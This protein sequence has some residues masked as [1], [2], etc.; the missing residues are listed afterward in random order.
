MED[1]P[2]SLEE[3]LEGDAEIL[4]A[5]SGGR[6][7]A[8]A[9]GAADGAAIGAR[10][11]LA[12]AARCGASAGAAW[13]ISRV[14]PPSAVPARARVSG[15]AVLAAAVKATLLRAGDEELTPA[16]EALQDR[17]PSGSACQ[18]ASLVGVLPRAP[19]A[20]R[21]AWQATGDAKLLP[22]SSTLA[23]GEAS[24]AS[25]RPFEAEL[26]RKRQPLRGCKASACCVRCC[27]RVRDPSLFWWEK[28][29]TV[30]AFF[31]VLALMWAMSVA[32][33]WPSR[34]QVW[35]SF[36]LVFNA[37]SF[38]LQ[39]LAER[40]AGVGLSV[41][42]AQRYISLWG[43]PTG[44]WAHP[45]AWAALVPALA[46]VVALRRTVAR[47]CCPR[48]V[49]CGRA[50]LLDAGLAASILLSLP[51]QLALLRVYTCES[52]PDFG[53]ALRWGPD[54]SWPCFDAEDLR[55]TL[56]AALCAPALLIALLG[57]T[58]ALAWSARRAVPPLAGS[59]AHERFLRWREAAY[60]HAIGYAWRRDGLWTM[61]SFVGPGGAAGV[62]C[63]DIDGGP[64]AVGRGGGLA[65][66]LTCGGVCCCRVTALSP[67]FMRAQWAA[68]TTLLALVYALARPSPLAQSIVLLVVMLLWAL[69]QSFRPAFRVASSNR[70]W[71][72]ALWG[73]T[74]FAFLSLFRAAGFQAQFTV[75][76]FFALAMAWS[77]CVMAVL[78][79]AVL[80]HAAVA[81]CRRGQGLVAACCRRRE[82]PEP[83][84]RWALA[85]VPIGSAEAWP[86]GTVAPPDAAAADEEDDEAAAAIGTTHLLPD[87]TEGLAMV[88]AAQSAGLW[89]ASGPSRSADLQAH[90]SAGEHGAA[91]AAMAGAQ[92]PAGD[93][94]AMMGGRLAG[95]SA[96]MFGGS[97]VLGTDSSA[98][99]TRHRK[100]NRRGRSAIAGSSRPSGVGADSKMSVAPRAAGGAG[101]AGRGPTASSGAGGELGAESDDEDFE[102]GLEQVEDD[103]SD[104]EDAESDSDDA[105]S[106]TFPDAAHQ[107]LAVASSARHVLALS[108][109]EAVEECA[110]L[111]EAA[112]AGSMIPWPQGERD[113]EAARGRIVGRPLDLSLA[114]RRTRV[115]LLKLLAFS[116]FVGRRRLKR[117]KH[118]PAPADDA[119][120]FRLPLAAAAALLQGAGEAP[121]TG[122]V[123]GGR[124]RPFAAFASDPEVRAIVPA[125]LHPDDVRAMDPSRLLHVTA[126]AVGQWA[127]GVA[128][129][130]VLALHAVIAACRERWAQHID[131]AEAR[132]PAAKEAAATRRRGRVAWYEAWERCGRTLQLRH[133]DL[134]EPA[135]RG[136]R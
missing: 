74:W 72:L 32:W 48:D 11:G 71:L 130:D 37:D 5:Q 99:S 44:A 104:G 135:R 30:V 57:P 93:F 122:S 16:S 23:M 102:A 58:A 4:E 97:V 24:A 63:G 60:E 125:A 64:D 110:A 75:D 79:A 92:D 59:A 69:R 101:G 54:P 3:A 51:A 27:P 78:A 132:D 127:T 129:Q 90:G 2:A 40:E 56:L 119:A 26:P 106:D 10:R 85:A 128:Q 36:T 84:R 41:G 21:R 131:A 22:A 53:G 12:H 9:S 65:G 109:A 124:G 19:E 28:A 113:L 14:A 18:T 1:L 33:P 76:S 42:S 62:I 82:A 34:W 66:A 52:N 136:R 73:L 83:L 121:P 70:L 89:F 15:E 77:A 68:T 111:A 107:Q 108:L 100:P 116:A 49:R 25:A 120:R 133:K 134:P 103:G 8:V 29:L 50:W 91:S 80:G 118:R 115:I 117:I 7:A 95:E 87:S 96:V 35:S 105:G 31:Q 94:S 86:R 47:F 112:A 38:M 98:G 123:P 45:I 6:R 81:Q 126:A 46:A 20:T 17:G 55:H 39:Y 114:S 88:G 43:E 13:F 61:S 67:A